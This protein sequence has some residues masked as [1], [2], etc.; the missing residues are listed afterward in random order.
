MDRSV[1][2]ADA[3][4]VGAIGVIRSLGRAGYRVHAAS[5]DPGALGLHSRYAIARAVHPPYES[6]EFLPWLDAYIARCGIEAIVP[7]EAFLHVIGPHYA[8][9]APL[10]PDAPGYEVWQRCM[11]KVQTHRCLEAAGAAGDHLPPGGVLARAEDVPGADRLAGL[12]AP[13]YLKGDA[14]LARHA[15]DA[16]VRRC[17]DPASVGPA[18]REL[19]ERYHA[20]LWQAHAPGRK[21]GVSLWRHRGEFRAQSM[22]LGIHMQPHTG[23]MMSLRRT[24]WHPTILAD[25]RAKVEALGWQGVC[26]MEY[27]WDPRTDEFWFIEINA[28][29][30]GYLHLDLYAGKDF[31]ALQMDAFFG[32]VR[33]DLDPPRPR[34]SCRN[35]VPGEISHV[36]SRV[37]DPRVRWPAKAASVLGFFARFLHPTERADLLFPGDRSLYWRA[38]ARFLGQ[39]RHRG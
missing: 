18:A 9:Y 23:G 32:R 17:P 29:F 22:V 3:H 13:F 21:V 10:L 11:S 33:T 31:P 25:A 24:F 1:L 37:R 28:R 5:A 16:V 20:I 6:A 27:K 34:V 39:L 19:L 15:P 14:G 2:V 36:L 4:A 7:S 12:L 38:W 35:T 8:R 26:M 30:W